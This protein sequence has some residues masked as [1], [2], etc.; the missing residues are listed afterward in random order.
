[1]KLRKIRQGREK[2]KLLRCENVG[3]RHPLS[4]WAPFP[5]FSQ[6]LPE[7]EAPGST[8]GFGVASCLLYSRENQAGENTICTRSLG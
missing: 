1:M 6:R 2:D 7:K 3:A 8:W 4:M 5:K